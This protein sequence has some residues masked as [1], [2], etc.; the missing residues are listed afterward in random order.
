MRVVRIAVTSEFGYARRDVAKGRIGII[1]PI[2][3]CPD[4]GVDALGMFGHVVDER[5]QHFEGVNR[6]REIGRA[7]CRERV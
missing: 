2:D 4:Q 6:R 1:D 5:I 3:F 7:S